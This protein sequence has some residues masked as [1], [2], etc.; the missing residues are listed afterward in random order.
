MK[1]ERVFQ[2]EQNGK[3]RPF[4]FFAIIA[5]MAQTILL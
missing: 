1:T 4:F 2:A 5:K 3:K